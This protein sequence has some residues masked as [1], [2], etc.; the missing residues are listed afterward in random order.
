MAEYAQ[1]KEL[2]SV[3]ERKMELIAQVRALQAEM[4]KLNVE[5][6]RRGADPN[7]VACW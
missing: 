6:V 7:L 1:D 2:H 3:A 4:A 5:L